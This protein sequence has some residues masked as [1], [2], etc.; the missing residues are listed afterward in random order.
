[1]KEKLKDVLQREKGIFKELLGLLEE[2]HIF[3]VKNKSFDL[4][5]I[6][7]KIGDK[8]KEVA[9]IELERRSHLG[10]ESMLDFVKRSEDEELELLYRDVKKLVYELKLQKETNETLVKQ[11]LVFTNQLLNLLNPSKTNLKTYNSIG[12]VTR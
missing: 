11:S 3:I 6:L 12:K 7:E 2:Q 9:K 8:N 4:E 1:M 10:D 5:S